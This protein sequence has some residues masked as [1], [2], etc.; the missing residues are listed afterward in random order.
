MNKTHL[1]AFS[2]STWSKNVVFNKNLKAHLIVTECTLIVPQ[3]RMVYSPWKIT[4]EKNCFFGQS[5]AWWSVADICRYTVETTLKWSKLSLTI[6]KKILLVKFLGLPI[7]TVISI[8]FM[9]HSSVQC[10]V[11][12]NWI[13]YFIYSSSIHL[14]KQWIQVKEPR[15]WNNQKIALIRNVVH[16][17]HTHFHDQ[18]A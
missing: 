2:T 18:I 5:V 13:S 10:F 8:V 15:K 1:N 6:F 3:T 4:L 9:R 11:S 7:Q 12:T 16:Q 14:L 17:E